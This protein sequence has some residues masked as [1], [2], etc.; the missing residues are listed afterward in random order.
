MIDRF[1]KRMGRCERRGDGGEK[2][3][4]RKSQQRVLKR[5][6]RS[7]PK[8]SLEKRIEVKLGDYGQISALDPP[9]S[10]FHHSEPLASCNIE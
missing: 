4:I 3:R 8:G 10:N 1:D 2:G 5:E 6:K 9:L 7:N